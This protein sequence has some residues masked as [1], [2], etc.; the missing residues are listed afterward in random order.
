M[1]TELQ[2]MDRAEKALGFANRKAELAELAAK[3]KRIVEVTN[4]AGYQEC[5][6]ARMVLKNTRVDIQKAGKDARDDATKFSKAV[7]AKEKEL[8]DMIQPEEDRLQ[9]LQAEW[10]EAREK[11]KQAKEQAERQ[12][13]AEHQSRIAAIHAIPT[14]V[15]GRSALIIASRIEKLRATEIGEDFEEFADEASNAK[16]SALATLE[17][18]HAAQVEHEAEQ[19]RIRAEREELERLR[20]EQAERLAAEEKAAAA[21]RAEQDRIAREQREQEAAAQRAAE[22]A[23]RAARQRQENEAR[24]AREEQERADRAARAAELAA[25][26]ERQAAEQ[27][28]LDEDRAEIA[29]QRSEAERI[30]R[31]ADA[32]AEADR[33]SSLT[34][35]DAAHAAVRWFHDHGHKGIKVCTDLEH[36]LAKPAELED[37][38]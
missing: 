8:I 21:A 33:L 22:E 28:R 23:E 2:V 34:L 5:H 13:I 32:K 36:A 9:A 18:L 3:S 38:A 35:H 27:R 25:E 15:H 24:A 26:A 17:R 29:R 4:P 19:D 30:R 16:A 11:E 10:D 6:A 1:S 37:A 7:I 31:E 14:E 20:R 12:R